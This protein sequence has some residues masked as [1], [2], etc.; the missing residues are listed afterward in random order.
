MVR[1]VDEQTYRADSYAAVSRLITAPNETVLRRLVLD[2]QPHLRRSLCVKP[3]PGRPV[4]LYLLYTH[5]IGNWKMLLMP[6]LPYY[7]KVP[8]HRA[9]IAVDEV[10]E[11]R[12]RSA[13]STPAA[14]PG[15]ASPSAAPSAPSPPAL[16]AAPSPPSMPAPPYAP[17]IPSAP[18]PPYAPAIPS[19]PTL[20]AAPQA[21][22][23]PCSATPA[24]VVQPG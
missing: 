22:T 8:L 4:A 11:R 15:S 24:V 9:G 18:A 10:Q 19:A 2:P 17:T 7:V 6:P 3:P 5:P 1:S 21:P 12:F 16:P 14:A 20:P 13:D 23:C